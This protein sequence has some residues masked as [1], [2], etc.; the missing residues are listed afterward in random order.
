MTA[1]GAEAVEVNA[2]DP[3]TIHITEVND[4]D[5][6]SPWSDLSPVWVEVFVDGS[7]IL[8]L[9]QTSGSFL[10]TDIDSDGMMVV[11]EVWEWEFDIT[12]NFD[13]TV[14]AVGH[15]IDEGGWDK[16]P[17]KDPDEYDVVTI[18]ITPGNGGEGF[19]PGYWKNHLD[20]WVGYSPDDVFADVFGVDDTYD[21]TL[22]E[23]VD[24]KGGHEKAL[25][26]H[27]VAALLNAAHPGVDY[28]MTEAEVIALV[29][30]AYAT[31][32]FKDAAD[33]LAENNELGGDIE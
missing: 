25:G 14:E 16:T 30:D 13:I 32:D 33:Q 31:G 23:A 19:T 28:P 26:R 27:A 10:G 9:D 6:T 20:E 21:W 29:Q 12:T 22:G 11:G 8:T 1:N 2:G 18:T 15:G 7:L 3:V 24:A 17:P 5:P 4:S